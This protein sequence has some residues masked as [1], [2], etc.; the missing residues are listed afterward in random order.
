[1]VKRTAQLDGGA[2]AKVE[3][4]GQVPSALIQ[5]ISE[6]AGTANRL[7]AG[8]IKL[9][10]ERAGRDAA[11]KGI[12]DGQQ[13]ILNT[14]LLFK[15]TYRGR[16]YTEA[17][18][19]NYL[20][21]LEL[22]TRENTNKIILANPE[23]ALKAEAE[24]NSFLEGMLEEMPPELKE[25][26]GPQYLLQSRINAAPGIGRIRTNQR[27][28]IIAQEEATAIAN[29]QAVARDIP[30]QAQNLLSDE[31]KARNESLLAVLQNRE[32]IEARFDSKIVDTEGEVIG[33]FDPVKT[34]GALGI[35][36]KDTSISAI[37][38]QFLDDPNKEGYLSDFRQGKLD[39]S[40]QIQNQEGELVL[41]LRP[42]RK[43][44]DALGKWMGAE[45]TRQRA[46]ASRRRTN[47]TRDVG[48]IVDIYKKGGNVPAQMIMDAR[49]RAVQVGA[50]DQVARIEEWVD[51]SNQMES[52]R[53]MRPSQLASHL[54]QI[55]QS[56]NAAR[57]NDALITDTAIEQRDAVEGLLDEMTKELATDSLAWGN[58]VGIIEISPVLFDARPTVEI[59]GQQVNTRQL[60][61]KRVQDAIAVSNQYG[62]PLRFL[63]KQDGQLFNNVLDDPDVTGRQ[64]LGA[65]GSTVGFGE[66]Q[67]NVLAE[68]SDKAPV[69]AQ[70]G[71]LQKEGAP[72][73]TLG[74]ATDG[75]VSMKSGNNVINTG[76]IDVKAITA[77][78][79]GR[80]YASS[81]RT[82]KAVVDTAEAIYTTR[83]L[84][85]G[86]AGDVFDD[87]L[88]VES[89]QAAAGGEVLDG[90]QV[91]GVTEYNGFKTMAPSGTKADDFE[92]AVDSLA[93]DDWAKGGVN[94]PALRTRAPQKP[95]EKF[96]VTEA[97]DVPEILNQMDD[98][99]L[100]AVE[101]G[102]YMI[103][104][105]NELGGFDPL[106]GPTDPTS[107][108]PAIRN[109]FY[110]LDFK[111]AMKARET[112]VAKI[113]VPMEA[114]K[115]KAERP[116]VAERET[117]K[118]MEIGPADAILVFKMMAPAIEK[119]EE[120]LRA[121][122]DILQ[123]PAPDFSGIAGKASDFA[124][125]ARNGI[126]TIKEFYGQAGK[127][128]LEL[129]KS[130]PGRIK[131]KI[132]RGKIEDF[133]ATVKDFVS[134]PDNIAGLPPIENLMGALVQV[135]S[136]G[137]INLLSKKGAMGPAQIMPG[138]ARDI[139]DRS[140][141]GFTAEEI[142]RDPDKNIMAGQWYLTEFLL[143][144]FPGPDRLALALAA[145]NAGPTRVRE[146]QAAAVKRTK[147]AQAANIFDEVLRHLP[148]ETRKYVPKVFK[149]L[150]G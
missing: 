6:S 24:V 32:S 72:M 34:Q 142:L 41:D 110:V 56:F 109:G 52:F 38:S 119:V 54:A 114:T 135:E 125:W 103:V 106:R 5:D 73:T 71:G 93:A 47:I 65:I 7:F 57:D 89:L 74:D 133:I 11:R 50:Q 18:T 66:F 85:Q 16:A 23:N 140:N 48:E 122:G 53:L 124:E 132:G 84:R 20:N 35:F 116:E 49:Q 63:T 62:T 3:L 55:D 107:D 75:L 145:Y 82:L 94:G 15:D 1:M 80:A 58:T 86:L 90:D 136:S 102:K 128:F 45:I 10:K 148:P 39:K 19:T 100:V 113:P 46:A 150:K 51:F 26:I 118:P 12:V 28:T 78:T 14:E 97:V 69:L 101:D 112:R 131:D 59:G 115:R 144:K 134:L 37:K 30:L 25:R 77:E 8:T 79:L 64:I 92:S 68:I 121:V 130:V 29:D 31:P 105:E 67:D 139:A 120:G 95:G 91:G 44:R 138:T 17:A 149:A 70:I 104:Q 146:A 60:M 2:G 76:S 117:G 127:D 129:A 33:A 87:E 9:L 40:Y 123:S 108:I 147:N 81:P 42:N 36:D 21:T 98:M 143:P 111:K 126:I 88:W 43:T 96:E 22:N 99:S 141:L 4:A 13:G 83:A 27:K 61:T 137:G